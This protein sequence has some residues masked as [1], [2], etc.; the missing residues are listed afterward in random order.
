MSKR[1]NMRGM[2]IAATAIAAV[3]ALTDYTNAAGVT[4]VPR[5]DR[6]RR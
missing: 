5:K 2:A 1:V 6:V 3:V 4:E